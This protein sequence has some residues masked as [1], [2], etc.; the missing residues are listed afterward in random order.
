MPGA[1][2]SVE[3]EPLAVG[4]EARE[5]LRADAAALRD[6]GGGLH[7]SAASRNR[8][9]RADEARREENHVP[10]TPGASARVQRRAGLGDDLRLTTEELGHL[11]ATLR[12]EGDLAAV[13]RPEREARVG[14]AGQHLRFACRQGADPECRAS[15]LA[16]GHEGELLPVGRERHAAHQARAVGRPDL[17]FGVERRAPAA[18]SRGEAAR[19]QPPQK[20]PG[21][22]RTG[23]HEPG[24]ATAAGRGGDR[25]RARLLPGQQLVDRDPRVADI[26][27]TVL[28]VALEAAS[29][30]APQLPWDRRGQRLPV[31]LLPQN[32]SEHVAHG[33]AGEERTA[34]EHLVEQ[35]AEGPDV[36]ALVDRLAARLLRRHVGGGAEDEPGRGPG[37]GE[38]GRLRQVPARPA[39]RS[40]AAPGLRETEVEDLDLALRRQLHVRGL[41]V[42]VD[43]AL[44]VGFFQGLGDL[45]READRFVERDGP[46]F[47][48]SARSSP[49]T[50]SMARK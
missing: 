2:R 42:A 40:V 38:G 11:E 47:S 44:L 16:T 26:V 30:Q 9:Q 39:A 33:V 36:G 1:A 32:R 13:R 31:D 6:P 34:G 29:E 46:R 37:V 50:S 35:D 12:E 49:S 17:E 23:A 28:G 24:R 3:E 10:R 18:A 8:K 45:L 48:R 19:Q 5:A 4:Q 41:Q 7:L 27:Q 25:V 43:D 15:V 14:G 20:E 22:E 21:R